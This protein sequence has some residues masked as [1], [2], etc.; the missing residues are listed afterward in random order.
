MAYNKADLQKRMDGAVE[1]LNKEFAGLRTGRAS[2]S[3][4]DPV[5]VDVYVRA[6]IHWRRFRCRK[7]ACSLFPGVGHE[8]RQSG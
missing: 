3:L 6:A 5:V 7:H 4:L 2:A 8:Q 1:N